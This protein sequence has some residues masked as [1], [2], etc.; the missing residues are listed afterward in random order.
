MCGI[1]TLFVKSPG[2]DV[3]ESVERAIGLAAHRGPDGRG[4][5]FG[6]GLRTLEPPDRNQADWV[7]GHARLS[8]IDLSRA[9]AQPMAARS[10]RLWITYNGEVYNYVEIR[11]EL[12]ANGRSFVSETDTEVVLA[13]Y[14]VWGESCVDRFIG[15]FAFVIVDLDRHCVFAARDR[16]GIKPL[17]LWRGSDRAALVSEPKQLGAFEGFSFTA[18]REQLADFLVDG[19][20]GHDPDRCCLKG[21]G[22]RSLYASARRSKEWAFWLVR[23]RGYGYDLTCRSVAAYPAALTRQR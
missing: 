13:A 6:N 1:A 11:S 17:Y 20:L 4:L 2:K 7:L 12:M 19:F 16:L 3:V 8:I 10:G 18:E 22:R 9:G 15:M 5:I 14:D 23:P 21:V